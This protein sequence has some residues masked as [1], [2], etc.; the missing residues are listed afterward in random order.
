MRW[1]MRPVPSRVTE[2]PLDRPALVVVADRG[3][4]A[5]SQLCRGDTV[6]KAALE[7]MNDALLELRHALAPA[8]EDDEGRN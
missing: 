6:L 3:L 8:I 4:M 2:P 1:R 7:E 5:Y